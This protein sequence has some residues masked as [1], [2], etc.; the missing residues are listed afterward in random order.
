MKYMIISQ[1]KSGTYLCANLLSELGIKNS[2]FHYKTNG[3]F[4]YANVSLEDAKLNDAGE[5]ILGSYPKILEDLEDNAVAM[6][7]LA[8]N[9]NNV[10]H[11]KD[12]KKILVK[13]DFLKARESHRRFTTET[14]RKHFNIKNLY[15]AVYGWENEPNTFTISFSDMIEKNLQI[16]DDLQIFLYDKIIYESEEAIT[17]ALKNDSVTKSSIGI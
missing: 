10:N 1:P 11:L 7:H 15:N 16:I 9:E 6:S 17:N 2:L 3:Y 14:N 13:R 12:F 4:S 5:E 8:Y